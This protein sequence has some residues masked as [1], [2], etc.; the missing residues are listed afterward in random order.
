MMSG[1]NIERFLRNDNHTVFTGFI[2]CRLDAVDIAH[3]FGRQNVLRRVIA[4]Y[5]ALTDEEKRLASIRSCTTA[6]ATAPVLF[7]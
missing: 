4:P 1:V 6:S 7:T 3:L 2:D 5:A